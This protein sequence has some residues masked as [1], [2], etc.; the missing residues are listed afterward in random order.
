MTVYVQYVCCSV[1]DYMYSMYV[2]VLVT[3]CTV[4]ML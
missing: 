4:C 3:I 1:S 2:V